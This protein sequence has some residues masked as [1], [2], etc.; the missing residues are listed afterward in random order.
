MPEVGSRAIGRMEA[1]SAAKEGLFDLFERLR[2]EIAQVLSLPRRETALFFAVALYGGAT[3]AGWG[4]TARER[5][6]SLE[7]LTGEEYR[8]GTVTVGLAHLARLGLVE[9]EEG[10]GIFGDDD[11]VRLPAGSPWR[12]IERVQR[13]ME[14]FE[15]GKGETPC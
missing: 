14:S 1:E 5:R 15:R 10:P 12:G 11:I 3:P 7:A 13:S 8:L 9:V 6:T 2:R 4:P